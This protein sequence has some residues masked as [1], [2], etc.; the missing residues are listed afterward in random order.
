MS[1]YQL[2]GLG[3]AIV[4][5]LVKVSDEELQ[6]Y[7][8]E[9]GAMNLVDSARQMELM[10]SLGERE[11]ELVSGGSNAN[12]TILFSQLGGTAALIACVSD[13]NYGTHYREEFESLDVGFPIDAIPGDATGTSLILVTPDSERSMQTNLGVSATMNADFIDE[14]VIRDSE[15][16]FIEGY[17][18]S[19]EAGQ[20]A[21]EKAITLA[22]KHD[23]QIAFTLSA[24]FIVEHFQAQVEKVVRQCDLLFANKEEALLC[25]GAE[26]VEGAAK[27]LA[28]LCSHTII[29]M[30]EDGA[31]VCYDG[32]EE[33]VSSPEVS[34]VDSTGAGDAFAGAYLYGLM[35]GC[36]PKEAASRACVLA[37]KVICQMGARFNGDVKAM[38]KNAL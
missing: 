1:R 37:S 32:T 21:V 30:S 31:L 22:K 26:D 24:G 8:I 29:T 2:S 25:S 36:T 17:L 28:A 3:N 19:N 9:K 35:N 18:L 7:G 16:L 15:W 4:D 23:T 27:E 38:W 33:Q 10:N 34:P 11:L 14:T 6:S 13:D 12:A 20:S 5:V